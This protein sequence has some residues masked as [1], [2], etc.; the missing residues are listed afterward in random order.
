MQS[1]H[2]LHNAISSQLVAAENLSE[3]LSKQMTALSLSSQN[4]ERK[5]VKELFESIGI[6][7]EAAF[8][9]PDT[10]GFMNTPPSKKIL[11]SDLTANKDQSRRN[12]ASVMRSC[13]PE[14]ARRRRDSLDQSWTCFEPPKTIVKRMLLQELQKTNRSESLISTNKGKKVFTLE[15][16]AS[17][18]IDARIPS[19]VF[20]ASKM[21]A[22]ILDSHQVSEHPKA[23]LPADSRRAPTQVSDSKSNV[24]QKSNILTIASQPAF[25]LSPTMVRGH[26]AET[27]DLAAE[28]LT[29]QKFDLTSNSENKATLHWKMPQKSLIPTYSTTETPS[30]QNKASEAPL[31][32]SKMTLVNSSTA[33]DKLSSAFTPESWRKG[34]PSSE[35]HSSTIS[36][37]STVLGKV[38]EFHVDKSLSK[39]NIPTVPIFGGSFKSL[40]SQAIKTSSSAL[41]SS[42]SSAGVPPVAVSATSNSL[43]SSNTST[44]SNNAISPSSL[45]GF[46]H[47]S[48][49]APKDTM[50]S[51]HNPPG[52]KSTVES[53][54]LEIEAAA[55]SN[56]KTVLDAAAEVVTQPNE[57][58]NGASELKIGP[59]KNFSPT[60]EQPSNNI[61]SSGLNVVSVSQATKPSDAPLQLS[62]SFLSS[63]SVS[64][65]KNEASD[66]GISHE[67]EMEEEAPET[68]GNNNT[69]ELSLGSFG[70]FGINSSPNPSM[71]KSNPFG[72][73]FNNIATSLS[74]S[75]V[76]FSVP[77]GELFKPASFT[78]SSPQP[79]APAQTTNSDA[80]S[81]GFNAVAP[82]PAQAPSGFGQPAQIGSG[83][84]VLGS[85]L[86]GFGQSRQLGSGLP[87]SGFAAPSGFGGFAGAAA[88]SRGFAGAAA[89]GVGFVAPGVGFAGAAAP[90]SSGGFGAFSS[91][92]GSGGFG[93]FGAAAGSKPPELFTQMRK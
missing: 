31:T 39:Q 68:S 54:K 81:G 44:D 50:L 55:A 69:A 72:G 82:T 8:G 67:D 51:L 37:P 5:N 16:S 40:S 83:Q 93:G 25:H 88:P 30:M 49:Q 75:P 26:S 73:S 35:S 91:Q 63:A 23:F 80:F 24:L 57:A 11:F 9:S 61:T 53:L 6:P 38:T 28:K 65:G 52:S 32:N 42:V 45:S 60:I 92:Q 3:C 58:L 2:S 84:Q 71:P 46:V 34:L 77:S 27:K 90:G 87:G 59:S 79:S 86:G 13:E 70:G 7:Y 89:P 64:N 36:A 33:G 43:T 76:T 78:F 14:T 22:G 20:H 41:S 47:L 12:Q 62:T 10:K 17:S 56:S 85:V 48:N 1:L 4:E 21:K 74:S 18:Q 15:E 29:V 66:V 19:I